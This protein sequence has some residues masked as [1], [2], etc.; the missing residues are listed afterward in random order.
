M[1]EHIMP[2]IPRIYTAVAE[3]MACMLFIL[4]VKKRFQKWQTAGIMAAVLLI[5]SV[6]LVMTDDIKDLFLDSLYDC[7]CIFND[8]IYLQLLRNYFY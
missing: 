2:D 8:R 5:Q 6:F 4:P 7:G 3:W 1:M